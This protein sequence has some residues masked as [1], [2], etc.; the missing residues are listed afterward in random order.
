MNDSTFSA[1]KKDYRSRDVLIMA[2]P[3]M[4][5]FLLEQIIGMMDV[6]FLGRVGEV[7][8]GAA[9]IAGTSFLTLAVIG[10]GYASAVQA[11][12]GQKNGER[13]FEQVGAAFRAGQQALLALALGLILLSFYAGEWVFQAIC[14]SEAVAQA[15]TQYLFWRVLGLP[16]V[17][18]ANMYRA[19][20]VATLR[21]N[22]LIKSALVMVLTNAVFNYVLIFGAGPIPAFGI[23]GAAMASSI[24]E[25]V[26]VIYFTVSAYFGQGHRHFGLF[27]GVAVTLALHRRLLT[28][29]RY[30]MVQEA[31]AFFAWVLFFVAIEHLGETPLAVSN[32][33]RQVA[34][35]LFLVIHGI[36]STCGAIAANLL[37]ENRSEEVPAVCRRGMR[38][39]WSL[40]LPLLI[41]SAVFYRPICMI[42]T[43]LPSV[44]EAAGPT[45]WV[46]I[47][48]FLIGIPSMFTLYVMAG[49]GQTKETSIAALTAI[50]GYLV[51]IAL[52]TQVTSNV[53]VIWTSD[54]VYYAL[55]GVV[56]GYFYRKGEWK[57][58][59]L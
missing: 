25:L 55:F 19:F 34:S 54:Y 37:G 50:G 28:L 31:L 32:V 4:L 24:A 56:I 13:A 8:L 46:M 5:S 39:C 16:F 51:Y 9:A 53:S 20:F 18:A 49:M 29:G 40:M 14:S 3:M 58:Q 33:V 2:A 12:M 6:A 36:G 45:F 52:M 1:T 35:T 10:W 26:C 43:Q 7:Q 59:R 22:I 41:G 47:G 11:Y 15:S 30:L 57:T 27:S 48:S 38:L 21:P 44:L 17:F 42:F 23:A